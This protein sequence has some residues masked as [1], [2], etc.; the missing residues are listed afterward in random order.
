MLS[1]IC[2]THHERIHVEERQ[3]G[4]IR[5]RCLLSINAALASAFAFLLQLSS[6]VRGERTRECTGA[7]DLQLRL[8]LDGHRAVQG[9]RLL[10]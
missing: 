10:S 3:I 6:A 9:T 2:S 1:S 4:A 5:F 7:A 8:I